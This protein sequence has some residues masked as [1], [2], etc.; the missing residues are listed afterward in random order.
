LKGADLALLRFDRPIISALLLKGLPMG[1][2]MVVISANAVM[3]IT[4]VNPF[5][6]DTT[7]AYGASWQLWNYVQMPALALGAAISAMAAQNVGAKQ[8][9]R[10]QRIAKVGIIFSLIAT[11]TAALLLILF[12]EIALKWFLPSDQLV[13][14]ARH[15][16][17]IGAPSFVFFGI[18]MVLFGVIRATGAVL[19]PLIILIISLWGFRFPFA[20][21]LMP[22]LGADAIWWSFP[23]AAA[24]SSVL[25][26]TYYRF[27]RWRQAHMI[28]DSDID[29]RDLPPAEPNNL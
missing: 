29:E 15:I 24:L 23:L 26:I 9:D 19:P 28:A 16:N 3:I 7:A 1:L 13:S 8:W 27:G 2:Q 21:L 20:K 18:S 11:L 17:I 5:G 14:I 4:L 22:T 12:D 25:S 6:S 10:V